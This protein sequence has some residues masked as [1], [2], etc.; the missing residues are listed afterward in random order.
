MHAKCTYKFIIIMHRYKLKCRL[1][2]DSLTLFT[3]ADFV[4]LFNLG[5]RTQCL[6]L[7]IHMRSNHCSMRVAWPLPMDPSDYPMVNKIP[8]VLNR[9]PGSGLKPITNLRFVLTLDNIMCYNL[10]YFLISKCKYYLC[11]C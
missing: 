7:R 3:G 11:P 2:S 6:T 10:H 5:S 1:R 8:L 4:C 9:A